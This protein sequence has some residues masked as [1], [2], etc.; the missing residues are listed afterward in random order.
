VN[1]RDPNQPRHKLFF[2]ILPRNLWRLVKLNALYLIASLPFF[3]ITMFVIKIFA[4]NVIGRI[5]THYGIDISVV[6]SFWFMVFLGAGPV[7]A[8]LTFV[9]REW[10][11][12]NPCWFASD[13]FE[14]IKQNFKQAFLLWLIDLILICIGV[15][16]IAYY[17]SIKNY[18]FT[19]AVFY[20]V[21]IYILAH[22]YIYQMMITYDLR[23]RDILKNSVLI[24]MGKFFQ[25]LLVLICL[26][27]VYVIL[28]ILVIFYGS[29]IMFLIL[30]A[31]EILIFP[32]L[33]SFT[34]N[35]YIYPIIK[36]YCG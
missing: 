36:K 30:L 7:N 10:G 17:M 13:F 2:E 6:L 34:V 16:A 12:E 1:K 9:V 23:L 25:S 4:V 15:Y 19:V 8:G 28:P 27:L 14:K 11:K 33:C 31:A 22:I 24:A 29:N 18:I 26:L 35:F 21:T 32:A 3:F 20:I 5:Y